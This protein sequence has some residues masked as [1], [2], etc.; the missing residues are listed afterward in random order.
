MANEVQRLQVINTKY[1][2]TL[3]EMKKQILVYRR[4]I[5]ELSSNKKHHQR[6]H[7]SEGRRVPRLDLSKLHRDSEDPN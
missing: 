4:E 2:E 1:E 3:A 5:I 6:H 7:K